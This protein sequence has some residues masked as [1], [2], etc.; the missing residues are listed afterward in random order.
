MKDPLKFF[1]SRWNEK[2]FFH[3]RCKVGSTRE[4]GQRAFD[5]FGGFPTFH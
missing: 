3:I 5:E 2:P 1:V 4:T